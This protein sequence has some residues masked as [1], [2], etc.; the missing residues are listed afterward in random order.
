MTVSL[1]IIGGSGLY[2]LNTFE[3][4]GELPNDTPFGETSS[5]I[6]TGYFESAEIAFFP[7]HGKQ[8]QLPPHKINYRANIWALKQA[9]VSDVIAVNAVGGIHPEM[10]PESIVLPDQVIDYTS[11]REH[12]FFDGSA[13]TVRHVD[14]TYP[15]SE[16]LRDCLLKA[17]S[18]EELDVLERAVYG[19][20]NGPR[21]ETAAEIRRL[22]QDGCDLVGMTSMPE[23]V[24][25]REL[26]IEYAAVAFVVNQAAGLGDGK[27]ITMEEIITHMERGVKK[28]STLLSATMRQLQ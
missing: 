21:L 15:Y 9:G 18:A 28:I 25:A 27:V 16:R 4:T 1:A 6:K 10:E 24:L 22:A 23:A 17:A 3:E 12:S 14:F 13:A 2:E 20:T 26:D 5:T 11:G 8:H 7:R 19:C